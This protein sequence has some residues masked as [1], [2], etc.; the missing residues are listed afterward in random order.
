MLVINYL[1]EF[2]LNGSVWIFFNFCLALLIIFPID[3]CSYHNIL[4]QFTFLKI[5]ISKQ[6]NATCGLDLNFAHD[7][8]RAQKQTYIYSYLFW[9]VLAGEWVISTKNKY[10]LTYSCSLAESTCQI[11]FFILV[12][13]NLIRIWKNVKKFDYYFY[14]DFK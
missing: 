3:F 7:S 2:T 8:A 1:L 9:L 5:V 6:I 12:F 4:E 13:L 10:D 14:F 11:F